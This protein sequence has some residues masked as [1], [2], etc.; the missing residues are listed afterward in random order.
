MHATDV[1]ECPLTRSELRVLDLLKDG[2]TYNEIAAA[3]DRATSTVRSQL[4][5]AYRRLGVTTSHQAVL[6]CVKS[7]WLAWDEGDPGQV[8]LMRIEDLFRHL[9][10]A[11]EARRGRDHEQLTVAQRQYLQAFDDH[12]QAP[13]CEQQSTCRSAMDRALATM[14]TEAGVP[15]RRRP[16]DVL[17]SLSEL[18]NAQLEMAA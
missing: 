4:H 3:V 10:K 12:L 7:G 9:V 1:S 15:S 18:V 11:V 17:D 14:L 13:S 8:T 16:R 2:L 5:S 6:E